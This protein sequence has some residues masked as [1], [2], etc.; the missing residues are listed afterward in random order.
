MNPVTKALIYQILFLQ[1]RHF[2]SGETTK[3]AEYKVMV[4]NLIA[5][6]ANIAHAELPGALIPGQ[7]RKRETDQ[8]EEK[9][10][11]STAEYGKTPH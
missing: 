1:S 11:D 2:L 7:K 5:K 3:L 9:K 6:Q 10:E 8:E 4:D